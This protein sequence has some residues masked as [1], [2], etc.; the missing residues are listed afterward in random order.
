MGDSVAIKELRMGLMQQCQSGAV[1]PSL[2][3]LSQIW[4]GLLQSSLATA[5]YPWLLAQL[6]AVPQQQW[7]HDPV[8]T[9][10]CVQLF[11]ISG[12]V[13]DLPEHLHL[14]YQA[15]AVSTAS[16]P[17]SSMERQLFATL[18]QHS[19]EWQQNVLLDGFEM[20]AYWPAYKI[21]IEVDGPHH[22]MACQHR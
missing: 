8:S 2:S 9:A 14:A 4:R 22:R 11:H 10:V 17:A 16:K 19:P 7:A 1:S 18:R 12:R 6:S 20:D 3:G 15:L 13:A 5:A 21:N